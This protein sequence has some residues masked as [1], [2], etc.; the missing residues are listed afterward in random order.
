MK[1]LKEIA[2][3]EAKETLTKADTDK[4]QSLKVQVTNKLIEAM[5]DNSFDSDVVK[6]VLRGTKNMVCAKVVEVENGTLYKFYTL[7]SRKQ[8]VSII[9]DGKETVEPTETLRSIW[10]RFASGYTE[11]G[12]ILTVAELN[13]VMNL[14]YHK[15]NDMFYNI[16]RPFTGVE[17][18]N[19]AKRQLPAV[20]TTNV[21]T[22]YINHNQ[23]VGKF[24]DLLNEKN[25]D[26]FVKSCSVLGIDAQ[27]Y[28]QAND[29]PD[30]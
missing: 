29:N 11:V 24:V 1:E 5:Q 15:T 26:S 7:Q 4:V 23:M 21:G 9:V 13:G 8:T 25:V 14:T 18:F 2:T 22:I 16:V 12:K 17:E 28:L 10:I 27:K 30:F 19:A 20:L 3:I 6:S